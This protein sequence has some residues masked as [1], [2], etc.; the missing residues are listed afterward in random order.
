[1][2]VS[3]KLI[4]PLDAMSVLMCLKRSES[5]NGCVIAHVGVTPYICSEKFSVSSW[6][7]FA[8]LSGYC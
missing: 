1:M 2:V 3:L 5:S 7:S 6:S 8:V 4:I